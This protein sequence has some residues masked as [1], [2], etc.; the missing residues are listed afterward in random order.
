MKSIRRMT[1]RFDL[2]VAP[3]LFAAMFLGGCLAEID[4]S[5]P[6]DDAIYEGHEEPGLEA[7]ARSGYCGHYCPPWAKE[8]S[9]CTLIPCW[10]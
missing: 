9:D 1:T 3:L 10:D 5:D 4:E 7:Q 8:I 6:Y 2:T